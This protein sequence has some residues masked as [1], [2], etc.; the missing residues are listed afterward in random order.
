MKKKINDYFK[1]KKINAVV[2]EV[3]EVSNYKTFKVQLNDITKF[4]KFNNAMTKE[5]SYVLNKD[6]FLDVSDGITITINNTTIKQDVSSGIVLNIGKTTDNKDVFVDFKNNPHWL[7]GGSTGSGKSVFMNNVITQ[8]IEKYVDDIEF[9][10]VD[11]KQVE[12]YK[13]NNLSM[14]IYNVANTIDDAIHLL[15]GAIDIMNSRYEK[16]KQNGVLSIE[17]YNNISEY[18]D[19]YLFIIIDELAELMLQ[20]KKEIQPLLQRLLQLGRASGVYCICATQRPST[21]VINGVL[22]VNFT[23][24]ICFKVSNAYDSRTIIN[25]KGAELLGGNGDGLLLSNGSFKLVRFQGFAPKDNSDLLNEY[26]E[27]KNNT[28]DYKFDKEKFL[29]TTITILGV[30]GK[31]AYLTIKVMSIIAMVM[32]NVIIWSMV[33]MKKL[34]KR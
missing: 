16:Y 9:G 29:N 8:L 31:I 22:K 27:V 14:N 5:L 24:R 12:F 32:L 25:Q 28:I 30:I 34:S 26:V 4:N 21:D 19:K 11:L 2:S 33:L 17:D 18:R 6:V 7:V 3:V 23:T 13:Y 1:E 10:F 15:N 20:N